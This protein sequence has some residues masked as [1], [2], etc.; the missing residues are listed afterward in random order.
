MIRC[1]AFG[2]Q[3]TVMFGR[4][5]LRQRNR[6]GE[7]SS[8]ALLSLLVNC[9]YAHAPLLHRPEQHCAL[10]VHA[11]PTPRHVAACAGVGATIEVTSGIATTAAS[12]STRTISRRFNPAVKTAGGVNTSSSR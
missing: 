8:S 3:S 2:K 12:P 4:I 7:L 11:A 5:Y 1:H 9:Y 10:E 6:A